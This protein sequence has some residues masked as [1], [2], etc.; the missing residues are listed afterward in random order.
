MKYKNLFS[1]TPPIIKANGGRA[2]RRY[3]EALYLNRVKTTKRKINQMRKS[4]FSDF[5]K[6]SFSL[7]RE[8]KRK[9]RRRDQGKNCPQ[10]STQ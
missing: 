4:D 2:G 8:K 5:H 7:Q 9:G 6:Q 1:H 3:L 10:I